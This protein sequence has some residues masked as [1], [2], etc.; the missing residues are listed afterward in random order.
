MKVLDLSAMAQAIG[1]SEEDVLAELNIVNAKPF[2]AYAELVARAHRAPPHS[3]ERRYL[4][5]LI[6]YHF[7]KETAAA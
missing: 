3:S 2:T 6:A 1:I 5:G 4:F 7:V